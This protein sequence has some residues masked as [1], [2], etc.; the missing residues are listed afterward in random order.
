[1]QILKKALIRLNDK[2]GFDSAAV[3]SFST[4]FAIIPVLALVFST[5]SLSSYFIDLQQY[6]ENFLF[7]ALL[8]K[9]Y[10]V[11]SL[12]INKFIANAQQLR[13]ISIVFLFLTAFLLFYKIHHHINLFW[14]NKKKYNLGLNLFIY[15]SMLILG[16]LLLAGSLFVSSYLSASK[17]FV[18]IPIGGVFISGLPIILSSIGLSLLYYFIPNEKIIFKNAFKSGVIVAILLEVLK[19]FLII[20][21]NNFPLYELIYGTLSILFLFMLWLYFSW[22]LVLFGSSYSFCLHQ[23]NK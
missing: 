20:Y 2:N 16:P 15:L 4:L 1:M 8:P 13:G 5:F 22:I 23:K 6:L 3:L 19:Y 11:I 14:N 9:N 17:F 21:I 7:E 18:F 10:E 12:Y